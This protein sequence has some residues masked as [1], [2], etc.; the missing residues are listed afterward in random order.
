ME[1][2]FGCLGCSMF[3]IKAA[4][5]SDRPCSNFLEGRSGTFHPIFFYFLHLCFDC[6][7]IAPMEVAAGPILSYARISVPPRAQ[8]PLSHKP[9]VPFRAAEIKMS[10]EEA[11]RAVYED[12]PSSNFGNRRHCA[13]DTKVI[14]LPETKVHNRANFLCLISA[15]AMTGAD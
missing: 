7:C 15:L 11:A 1:V 14:N 12:S 4:K 9:Q 2:C 8:C 10:T 6:S 13:D 3:S 5:V